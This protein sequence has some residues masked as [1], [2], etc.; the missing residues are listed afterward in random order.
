MGPPPR[1]STSSSLYRACPLGESLSSSSATPRCARRPRWVS[2]L[3][4]PGT[5]VPASHGS[6]YK[7]L[8]YGDIDEVRLRESL[9]EHRPKEWP[10][11][12][13]VDAST[14][15]RCDAECSPERGFHYSRPRLGRTAH[16]GR[17]VLSVDLPAELGT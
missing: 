13:A 1:S 15:D 16:R 8:A 5:R 10:L 2:A 14:W 11:V 6:L 17:L 3:P 9:V 7:A 4:Q 12:F